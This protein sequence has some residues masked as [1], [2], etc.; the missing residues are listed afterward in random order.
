MQDRMNLPR[1]TL[2]TCDGATAIRLSDI[3]LSTG[4]CVMATRFLSKMIETV[5]KTMRNVEER[6][7][8]K[9]DDRALKNL[10]SNVTRKV[11][12]VCLSERHTSRNLDSR[13]TRTKLP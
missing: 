3:P 13:T 10:R 4:G 8:L 7:G 9:H 1:Q 5:E 6:E 11:A 12:E 2:V